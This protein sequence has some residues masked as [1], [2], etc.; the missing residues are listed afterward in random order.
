MDYREAYTGTK[1][2]LLRRSRELNSASLSFRVV[3]AIVASFDSSRI[4]RVNCSNDVGKLGIEAAEVELTSSV[5]VNRRFLK[6]DVP[7]VYSGTKTV[8]FRENGIHRFTWQMFVRAHASALRR[9]FVSFVVF[10]PS[11]MKFVEKDVSRKSLQLL[12]FLFKRNPLST[13]FEVFRR[14]DRLFQRSKRV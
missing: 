13:S 6:N 7:I 12:S 3:L 9:T 4:I 14:F 1:L 2:K 10:S 11:L 5:E 8:K